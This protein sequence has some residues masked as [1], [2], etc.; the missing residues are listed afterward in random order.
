M[1]SKTILAALLLV[2]AVSL[3][4]GTFCQTGVVVTKSTLRP[5]LENMGYEVNELSPNNY[6]VYVTITY[7]VY[8][9]VAF[10]PDESRIWLTT[11]FYD[12]NPATYTNDKLVK[13]L[14]ANWTTGA[15]VFAL[16]GT[17]LKMTRPVENRNLTPLLLK[18]EIESQARSVEST[19]AV[20]QD[21]K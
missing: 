11:F 21:K 8:M 4:A 18:K 9:A 15:S 16:D 3:P 19:E 12:K 13:L 7:K 20:W 5:M 1:K 17:K 14:Q 6:E 2:I 10:S